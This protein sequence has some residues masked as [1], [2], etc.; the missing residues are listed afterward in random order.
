MTDTAEGSLNN[1]LFGPYATTGPYFLSKSLAMS[2]KL[3]LFQ[4]FLASQKLVNL[5][6]QGPGMCRRLQYWR[7]NLRKREEMAT[8]T[9]IAGIVTGSALAYMIAILC[10]WLKSVDAPP[11]RRF[12]LTQVSGLGSIA[13]IYYLVNISDGLSLPQIDFWFRAS[14]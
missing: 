14:L 11:S 13:Y 8:P 5:A 7:K 4:N 12:T 1:T 9:K 3:S 6:C 2:T 10:G